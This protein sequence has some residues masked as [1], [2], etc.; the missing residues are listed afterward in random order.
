VKGSGGRAR[1]P[2]SKPPMFW[3]EKLICCTLPTHCC[4]SGF[5]Q[6]RQPPAAVYHLRCCSRLGCSC[7]R[8]W[9]KQCSSGS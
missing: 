6:L 8:R 2:L 1:A 3:K 4:F 7:C 5:Q 9:W